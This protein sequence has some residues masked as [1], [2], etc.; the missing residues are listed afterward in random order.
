MANKYVYS[1][2]GGAGTGDDWA[3][4]YTTLVAAFAGMS[5]GDTAYVAQN[6]AETQAS[7]MTLTSP[8]TAAA[9]CRVI[10]VNQAGS[11]PPVSADI[12]T[13]ATVTTTGNSAITVANGYT[14]YY[15]L[16]FSVGSGAVSAVWTIS[17]TGEHYFDTCKW[18]RAGT[19]VGACL[20]GSTSANAYVVIIFDNTTMQ[21]GNASDTI[22]VRTSMFRWVGTATAIA[23]ATFPTTLFGAS[24]GTPAQTF[25]EGV[26]LSA[27]GTAVLVSAQ[28]APAKWLFKDCK[29]GSG[30]VASATQSAPKAGEVVL[31]RCDS[32]DT[33]YKVEKHTSYTGK[34]TT[35]TTIVRSGGASDGTTPV[36]W[37]IETT[38]NPE[39]QSPFEC[40]PIVIWN[41]TTGSAVT[42]TIEGVWDAGAVPNNNDVWVDVEYLGTSGFPLGTYA[43]CGLADAIAA[44]TA[45]P[46]SSVTWTTTGL[47]TPV[48][49]ALSVQVT[50]QEKGPVTVYVRAAKA[51]ST[52]YI[53]PKIVLS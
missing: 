28:T 24:S 41:E 13:T 19:S 33:V 43:T 1:G 6:H 35:E 22:S 8:G 31:S 25:I 45:L 39:W 3:N 50:P 32:G 10:C 4:A 36:S 15:G 44:P 47:A 16:T 52:F 48:E 5:A 51:S 46:T 7:A 42:V 14:Y 17:G 26:D 29:L 34:H 18:V 49:F 2:A 37:K 12:A 9:P 21:F 20:L 23:G 38:A 40:V 30:Y 53:D 11:V 27:L